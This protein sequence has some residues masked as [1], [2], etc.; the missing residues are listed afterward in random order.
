MSYD[1]EGAINVMLN[2]LH[3]MDR[4][5]SFQQADGA[6]SLCMNWHVRQNPLMYSL[7]K[8]SFELAWTLLSQRRYRESAEWFLKVAEL[9]SWWVF[10]AYNL[11]V[12]QISGHLRSH[13]T[14]HYIAASC[15]L[16][17]G[18]TEKAQKLFEEIPK[19]L[20]NKK[21]AGKDLPTEV[22]IKKKSMLQSHVHF[23]VRSSAH[24][25]ISRVLQGKREKADRLR[26]RLLQEY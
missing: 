13:G 4:Q 2:G 23:H 26:D 7:E 19:L 22:L 3:T 6:V 21:I 11:T 10:Q 18:D 25:S 8:I 1:A 5:N 16:S 12:F 24:A 14:Y 17:A 9:N 20:E 15:Y